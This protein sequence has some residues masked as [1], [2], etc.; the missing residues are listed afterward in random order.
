MLRRNLLGLV[1][2]TSLI[3]PAC[4][5]GVSVAYRTHLPADAVASPPPGQVTI[6]GAG[7]EVH[8]AGKVDRAAVQEAWDG[9][10]A[11]MN[12]YLEAGVLTPLRSGGPAGELAPF[13]TAQAG[14]RVTSTASDRA[15]FVDEGL[16]PATGITQESA[17]ARLTALAGDDGSVSVVSAWLDVRLRAE[18][19][20]SRV[21]VTHGGELVFLPEGGDW[22]IDAYDVRASRDSSAGPTTT[23]AA[24]S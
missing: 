3:L 5:P 7:F 15:A 21:T 22:K 19:D 14:E 2:G 24:R 12:R 8:A 4:G 1:A 18:V 13:F 6:T 11:T 10:L 17:V 20:G 9:V 23:G 16:P